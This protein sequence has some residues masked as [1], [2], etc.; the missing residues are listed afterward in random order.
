MSTLRQKIRRAVPP[1]VRPYLGALRRSA[2]ANPARIGLQ[3]RRLM[4]SAALSAAE[5]ELLRRVSSRIHHRDGMYAGSGE[6]YFLAGLSA[7]ACIDEVLR[8]ASVEEVADF[9]DMP[10]GYGRELRFFALRFPRA[11]CTACDIQP[12]ATDFCAREFGA[13]PV[14]SR[15]RLGEVS[16][17]R[18][19]DLVW[20]GSLVTHL[21]PDSTR[22]LL[23][24]FAR[25]LKPRGV[26]VFTFHGDHVLRRMRDGGETYE[27]D[28]A[29]VP[30]LVSH[31]EGPAPRLTSRHLC[32]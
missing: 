11:T 28:P 30:A 20:C 29:A 8:A 5:R 18:K 13:R 32:A 6:Q 16:F 24:L 2:I 25:H 26:A 14:V 27:L 17:G 23:R 7:L 10:S 31:Y 15:P 4:K 19:F 1:A 21:D 12:G 3:K 22:E 9:L